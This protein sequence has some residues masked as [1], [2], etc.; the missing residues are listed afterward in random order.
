M[1]NANDIPYL[2]LVN[3]KWKDRDKSNLVK[4][5]QARSFEKTK[6]MAKILGLGVPCYNSK[7]NRG[8]FS[9]NDIVSIAYL[10]GYSVCFVNDRSGD[11]FKIRPS[12]ETRI[13]ANEI[14]NQELGNIT[15]FVKET[16]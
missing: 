5:L 13:R 10:C 7:I 12:E 15:I 1:V 4:Y 8:S 9:F 14:V 3:E 6:N 16:T 2:K 11:S